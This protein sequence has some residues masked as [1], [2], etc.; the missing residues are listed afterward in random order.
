VNTRAKRQ[1]V[2]V[3]I[4][5]PCCEEPIRLR[6]MVVLVNRHKTQA[7]V[8]QIRHNAR[9]AKQR[10]H[11]AGRC[12][13]C[14]GYL[15]ESED[16]RPDGQW[17]W[18]CRACRVAKTEWYAMRKM[19]ENAEKSGDSAGVADAARAKIGGDERRLQRRPSPHHAPTLEEV[20]PNG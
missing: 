18:K 15:S 2:A 6:S 7:K 9:S 20:R 1:S 5:C 13:E 11:D 17:R 8:D 19:L 4:R 16:R 12:E 14:A 3:V 10:L